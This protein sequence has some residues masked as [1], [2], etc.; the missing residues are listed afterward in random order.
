MLSLIG[1]RTCYQYNDSFVGNSQGHKLETWK[2]T[3]NFHKHCSISCE[4]SHCHTVKFRTILPSTS[5]HLNLFGSMIL[6]R[7]LL[8][9][10][11]GTARIVCF[12]LRFSPVLI[13]FLQTSAFVTTLYKTEIALASLWAQTLSGLTFSLCSRQRIQ[14]EVNESCKSRQ[15]SLLYMDTSIQLT[16]SIAFWCLFGNT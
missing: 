12:P 4:T 9:L 15:R 14:G 7:A 10:Y 13:W 1:N 3:Q 6:L 5:H 2:G 8:V 11:M 16:T